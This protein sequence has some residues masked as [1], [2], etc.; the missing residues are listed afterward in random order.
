MGSMSFLRGRRA[1]AAAGA[2]A[3][4]LAIAGCGSSNS[5]SGSSSGGASSGGKTTSLN[6]VLAWYP[7]PEYGGLYAAQS[8][9]YFKK[10]GL[11]V[12]IMPGGPQVSATQVVGSGQATIGYLN[13]DETLMEANENGIPLTEFATTYQKYPEA[14]EYHMS[15]PIS[16]LQQVNGKV[17]SG[18]TGSVDYQWLQHKYHLKNTVTPFSYATFSHNANSLLL[19]YAPDDVPTLAAQGVKIGYVPI[20]QSGLQPYADILFAKSSYVT[21]N[22]AL[23]RKFLTAL[24]QGW[25]YFHNNYLTVD[26]VIF[27]ADK[28]TPL[29]VDNKIAKVEIPF[30][31]GGAATTSGIGSIN[32]T[33]VQSTYSK[34]RALGVLKKNLT[35]SSVANASL[36]PK[37]LPP[38]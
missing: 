16:T 32:L 27:A 3:C 18:V 10:Q 29:A 9:G 1:L 37:L 31:Y 24:G 19:G 22:Q 26:K 12:H 38:S 30:I 28:T 17:L 2:C 21:Q 23:I 20:D 15:N 33:R 7:T 35:V 13:N 8:Q 36:V 25:Q 5:S 4:L 11:N 14:I 34:L 6:V